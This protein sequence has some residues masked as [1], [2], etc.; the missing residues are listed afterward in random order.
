MQ[1]KGNEHTLA[2]KTAPELSMQ[3][4]VVIRDKF[5]S[6]VGYRNFLQVIV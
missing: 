1:F 2:K 4:N 5:L 6:G 3:G